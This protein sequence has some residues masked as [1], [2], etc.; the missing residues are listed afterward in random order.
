MHIVQDCLYIKSSLLVIISGMFTIFLTCELIYCSAQSISYRMR[1]YPDDISRKLTSR[2]F[3][4][5]Y[6]VFDM[7]RPNSLRKCHDCCVLS[8]SVDKRVNCTA[9]YIAKHQFYSK[10]MMP[11]N[12]QCYRPKIKDTARY[13]WLYFHGDSITGLLLLKCT[14][15]NPNMD[16]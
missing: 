5:N 6:I 8:F 16:I 13:K 12:N 2:N 14:D 3:D 15:F 10:I 11:Q 1:I 4:N 7:Y 9:K